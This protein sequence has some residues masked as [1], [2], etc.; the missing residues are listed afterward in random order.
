M[1]LSHNLLLFLAHYL[2]GRYQ[3]RRSRSRSISRSPVKYRSRGRD[4]S[5]SP[6]RG[7]SPIADCRP[8]VSDRLRS[9][10][11]PRG[12][13]HV[14]ERGRSRSRSRAR[15][16][17]ASRSDDD[18]RGKRGKEKAARSPSSSSR[19]SSPA[20]NALVSYGDGDS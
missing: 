12:N 19:S 13:C 20:G 2:C 3:S 1:K 8:A 14:A 6:R 11:G 10:L 17:S 7:R 16:S 9:R 18:R 15:G 5:L 4:H